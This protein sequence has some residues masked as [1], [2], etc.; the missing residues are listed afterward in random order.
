MTVP[1]NQYDSEG[2]PHGVWESYWP[3]GT[4]WWRGHW[5]HGKLHGLLEEYYKDGTVEG[6]K[7]YI[8][9]K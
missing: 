3:N 7:Y 5:L 4:P 1:T 8:T 6:K 9:I 2:R